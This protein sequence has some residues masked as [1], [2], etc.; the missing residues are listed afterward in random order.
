MHKNNFH[1]SSYKSVFLIKQI[2]LVLIFEVFSPCYSIGQGNAYVSVIDSLKKQL[3]SV[4]EDTSRIRVLNDLAENSPND[5]CLKYAN[6]ALSLSDKLLNTVVVNKSVAYTI[7]CKLLKARA[8]ENIAS[9]ME[10]TNTQGASETYQK[11]LDLETE[12]GNKP[13]SFVKDRKI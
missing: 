13:L 1:S 8:I 3:N 7:T 10:Q 4:T 2:L 12:T 11:A 5:S 9:T 6:I